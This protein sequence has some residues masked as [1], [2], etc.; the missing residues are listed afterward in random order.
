MVYQAITKGKSF[1]VNLDDKT[2]LS[3]MCR[4]MEYFV[5]PWL[6]PVSQ[7]IVTHEDIDYSKSLANKLFGSRFIKIG[8][9]SLSAWYEYN[10]S[11]STSAYS[12]A[13]RTI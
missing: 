2:F 13:A 11:K 10:R 12:F 6:K 7:N 3:S 5:A 4:C 8:C 9:T 1:S